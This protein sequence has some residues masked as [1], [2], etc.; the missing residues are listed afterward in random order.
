M[1][2]EKQGTPEEQ[3]EYER[4]MRAVVRVLYGSDETA[5]G[6]VDQIDPNDI[7]GST[8]KVSMIFIKELDRKINM[9]ES[10]VASVTEEAVTRIAELAEARHRVEYKGTDMEKIL[11]ATWEAV[12]S[13]FG[14]D[15]QQ[16]SQ[17]VQS[18]PP[19]TLQAVKQQHDRIL[20]S[21]KQQG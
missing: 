9:H 6:I 2:P 10:V 3:Q 1:L 8:A 20:A 4:A 17:I 12:Q 13:M 19:E 16:Y 7:V 5:R 21:G 15:P 14:S 11:G 18:L